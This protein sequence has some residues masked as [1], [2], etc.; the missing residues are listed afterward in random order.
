MAGQKGH[1]KK[2]P[3]GLFH[4]DAG[5]A[6]NSFVPIVN[7]FVPILRVVELWVEA[8]LAWS[9]KPVQIVLPFGWILT[10]LCA[11]F[12]IDVLPVSSVCSEFLSIVGL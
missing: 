3:S 11:P 6:V 5:V 7:S 8:E 2:K 12:S 1:Q 4:G 9:K 10:F